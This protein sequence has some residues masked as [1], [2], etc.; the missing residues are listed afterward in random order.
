M[1]GFN[2]IWTGPDTL[3]TRAELGSPEKWLART[4]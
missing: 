3:P 4:Q 1:D 2:T